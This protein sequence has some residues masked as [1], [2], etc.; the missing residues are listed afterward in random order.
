[1]SEFEVLSSNEPLR[2]SLTLNN[3]Q[4]KFVEQKLSTEAQ[5][6]W[7]TITNFTSQWRQFSAAFP[8]FSQHIHKDANFDVRNVLVSL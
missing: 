6:L 8:T 2:S 5:L 7:F 4:L 3:L 1:M